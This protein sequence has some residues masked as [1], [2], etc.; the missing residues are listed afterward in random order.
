MLYEQRSC[1]IMFNS[2]GMWYSI[3]SKVGLQGVELS[4]TKLIVNVELRLTYNKPQGFSP[5]LNCYHFRCMVGV[6]ISC[7]IIMSRSSCTSPAC[8]DISWW[9]YL[10]HYYL[11]CLWMMSWC[12]ASLFAV[13]ILFP[14]L[15]SLRRWCPFWVLSD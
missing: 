3:V 12:L 15:A 7:R 6:V 2:E 10:W 5:C 8:D 11:S 14:T 1:I 9:V 13:D 4:E